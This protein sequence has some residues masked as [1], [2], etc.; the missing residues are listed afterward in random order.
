MNPP[1][2]YHYEAKLR[3]TRIWLLDADLADAVARLPWLE[4]GADSVE[5]S[6]TRDMARLARADT[7]IA[8][9]TASLAWLADEPTVWEREA[10]QSLAYLAS[11]D[12]QL[13]ESILG[14]PW[15]SDDITEMEV[16]ALDDLT[17][18]S[19]TNLEL[20]KRIISSSKFA[21]DISEVESSTL[22]RLKRIGLRDP[23]LA[24]HW[25][26]Y[27]INESGPLVLHGINTILYAMD[28][29]YDLYD[30]SD[31]YD[32]YDLN[33][34]DDWWGR[35]TAQPWFADGLDK[36]EIASVYVLRFIANSSKL[37]KLYNDLVKTPF[38]QSAT[39]SLPLAGE[40]NLWAF[41]TQPFD[42]RQDLLPRLEDSVRILEEF[43]GVPFPVTNVILAVPII[44]PE[45]DHGIGGGAHWGKFIT[46]T[47]YEPGPSDWEAIYHEVAHYY[48]R[49][50]PPWLV[51]GGAEFMWMYIRENRDGL[52]DIEN[53]H[54]GA[55]LRLQENCYSRGIR[56][57]QQLN[58]LQSSEPDLQTT[59]HYSLG[60]Y[61]LLSLYKTLG[62]EATS[63]AL[64]DLYLLSQSE[65]SAAVTEEEIYQAFLRNTPPGLEDEFLALYREFHTPDFMAE[66]AET[67]LPA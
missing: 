62:E 32:D 40:V 53:Q 48:F 1:D 8:R 45:V 54:S 23:E 12:P 49:F 4:D 24:A 43:M 19:S 11:P 67:P 51:E 3:L 60:A 47:R 28:R 27:A 34:E 57:L 30:S 5:A 50:G 61:F 64:R 38:I 55:S 44:G 29:E 7:D 65:G 41:Q 36:E 59:C 6:V 2:S 14:L 9:M 39:V 56:S 33:V 46:V 20:A 66:E 17:G 15:F 31:Y 10:I 22:Y 21:D 25:G 58:E 63:A 52:G 37:G 18:I 26:E 42:P 35:L 16:D 13:A